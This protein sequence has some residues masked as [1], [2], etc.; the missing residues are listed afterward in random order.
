MVRTVFYR[1]GTIVV[2]SDVGDSSDGLDVTD[3]YVENNNL[4]VTVSCD[5]KR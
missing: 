5:S 4:G 3:D 1:T 2:A